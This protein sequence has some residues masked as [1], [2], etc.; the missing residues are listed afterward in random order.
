MDATASNG[1]INFP[2]QMWLWGRLSPRLPQFSGNCLAG[3]GD[4]GGKGD[5]Q[6]NW[7]TSWPCPI[8]TWGSRTSYPK[9]FN[10]SLELALHTSILF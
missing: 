4:M 8:K 1:G 10:V 6:G 2:A 9:H 3:K 5:E 7:S